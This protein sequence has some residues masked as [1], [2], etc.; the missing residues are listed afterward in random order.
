MYNNID[1]VHVIEVIG[2]W[3]DELAPLVDGDFPLEA[4]KT[5]M[6]IT[7]MTNNIFE[8]GTL[9]FLQLLGTSMGTSFHSAE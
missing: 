4:I 2:W 5:A 3:L 7:I 9:T 8:W 6:V 1:T